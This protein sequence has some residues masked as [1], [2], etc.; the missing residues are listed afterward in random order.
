[1]FVVSERGY[2]LPGAC[3]GGDSRLDGWEAMQKESLS[4]D[5]NAKILYELDSERLS[6]LKVIIRESASYLVPA[7]IVA[8]YW[9]YQI[10]KIAAAYQG[11]EP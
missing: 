9:A 2:S 5:V 4:A 3:F 6:N 10:R 11:P 1:L 7:P 8:P